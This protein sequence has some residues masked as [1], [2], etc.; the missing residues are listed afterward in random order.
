A[1]W[2]RRIRARKIIVVARGRW[3][4]V[5]VN[6]ILL[7]S[8]WDRQA[9]ALTT[10]VEWARGGAPGDDRQATGRLQASSITE[11]DWNILGTQSRA[12]RTVPCR[13]AYGGVA[14][15]REA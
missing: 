13:A 5:R 10:P 7:Y 11:D 12:A 1:C 4:A 8:Q 14:F 3:I 2:P 9:F 15:P 6:P